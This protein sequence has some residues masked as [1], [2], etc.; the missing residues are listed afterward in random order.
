MNRLRNAL[1][2]IVLTVFAGCYDYDGTLGIGVQ[3]DITQCFDADGKA[4]L[5]LSLDLSLPSM[6]EQATRSKFVDG[7]EAEHTLKT[8][9]LVLFHG[10]QTASE[11]EMT[12]ATT[13]AVD[14]HSLKHID[15][16]V[17]H[18]TRTTIQISRDYLGTGDRLC[19]LAIANL[20]PDISTGQTF[21]SVKDMKLSS[22]T[23][24]IDN[25]DYYVMTNSPTATTN[26]GQ[27]EIHTLVEVSPDDLFATAEEAEQHP[28]DEVYLERA[29][30]RLTVTQAV[31]PMAIEGNIAITF[32]EDDMR[33]ALYKYN[34]KFFLVRHFN[35]SW[36]G[37]NSHNRGYRFT[38]SQAL[39]P[40]HYRTCWAQDANYNG[41]G[42][43]LST[44]IGW[45][46]I[47]ESYYMAEN[48]FDTGH[49]TSENTTAAI[50]YLRL[51]GGSAFYTASTTG[52]DIIYQLPEP[53]LEEHGT[54]ANVTF[55]RRQSERVSTAK[56][57]DEYLRQWLMQTNKDFRQWVD[58]YAGGEPRHVRISVETA[59]GGLVGAQVTAVTQTARTSGEGVSRFNSLDLANYLNSHVTLNYYHEGRCFY[60]IPIRHFDDSLT[61]WQSPAEATSESAIQAYGDN[62]NDYL[63]RYGVVRNNWYILNITNVSHVGSPVAPDA[64]SSPAADDHIEQLLNTT[65]TIHGWG[66]Q[67]KDLR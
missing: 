1:C 62:A 23:T 22:L 45:K 13:Y 51:N 38:E 63:G 14:Y 53:G 50:V 25:A 30:A 29:A 18:S 67:S 49:M 10:P 9:L 15:S 42:D 4:W 26:D 35:Q 36:L 44:T 5:S 27:G 60:H 33:F 47:G 34:Q 57:I 21:A 64:T 56:T 66:D 17:T 39:S 54:S 20:S 16:Q 48:T 7:D 55:S 28:T 31:S 12:V 24:S 32:T 11:D 58:D 65:L 59:S 37:Y 40:Q 2:L 3:R 6:P 43:K 52:S 41:T 46:A 19:L 8:L 61:P